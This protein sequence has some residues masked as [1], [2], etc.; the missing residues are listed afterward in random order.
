MIDLHTHIL[1]GV[2]DGP[3]D[4][5]TALRMARIAVADGIATVVVT[6]HLFSAGGDVSPED[7]DA[8]V[9]L[10]AEALAD[11]GIL[12]RLVPGFECCLRGNVVEA[13]RSTAAYHLGGIGGRSKHVLIELPDEMPGSC[14][15]GVLFEAQQVGLIPV[16]AHPELHPDLNRNTAPAEAFVAAGGKIQITAD[17]LRGRRGWQSK[18]ACV[19]WLRGG[20]VQAMASDAHDS[21][22]RP[23]ALR[24]ALEKAMK[25]I[26][27]AAEHLVTTGPAAMIGTRYPLSRR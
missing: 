11:H 22:R 3:E 26:G 5:D 23:P 18:R 16:L 8:S 21:A 17:A 12:L 25:L 20:L 13:A 27:P 15:A 2:D 24:K 7:R 10:L 4:L 19:R 9:T 1:P 6:P 14:L